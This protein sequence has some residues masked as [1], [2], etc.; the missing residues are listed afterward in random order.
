MF[1]GKHYIYICCVRLR[2]YEFYSVYE[3]PYK[4]THMYIVVFNI[5]SEIRKSYGCKNKGN[6]KCNII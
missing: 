2:T 3:Y 6:Y 5:M 1:S 4:Y